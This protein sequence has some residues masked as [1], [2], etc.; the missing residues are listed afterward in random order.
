MYKSRR[1][2]RENGKQGIQII[3]SDTGSAGSVFNRGFEALAFLMNTKQNNIHA[4]RAA[5][6]GLTQMHNRE[7][8]FARDS[9]RLIKFRVQIFKFKA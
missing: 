9:A 2:N 4:F 8:L 3:N 7:D 5:V 6:C 1:G